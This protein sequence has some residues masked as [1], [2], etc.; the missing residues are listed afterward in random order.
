MLALVALLINLPPIQNYIIDKA[1]TYLTEG[2]GYKTEI[3]YARI[4]WFNSIALD[5][6]RIYDENGITMIG[7][8]ELALTFSLKD[9][10]GKKDISTKEA[11]IKGA[12]VNLRD[13]ST[14]GLNIDEWADRISTLFASEQNAPAEPAVFSIDQITLLDSKFSIS[15]SRKDSISEGFDYNHFQLLDLNADLLNLKTISDTFQIDVKKLST[16]D[17]ASGLTIDNLETF[18]R[19]SSKGLI[20]FD[21]DLLMGKTHIKDFVELSH[22]R[23][24]QMAYFVD[25]VD[26][27]ADF[28]HSIIHTDELSFFA[29]ELKQYNEFVDISGL[30]QG[31]VNRFYSDNFTIAF[32]NDSKFR[33]S[34]DIEGLPYIN[35]TIFSLNLRESTL[36]A[37][38]LREYIG[39][40]AFSI[41]NK[42]GLIKMSGNFDGLINNF[43]ADGIFDTRMGHLESN[44]KIEIED[45]ELPKYSGELY[46]KDF[47]LGRF[48]EVNNFQRID[49]D[50]SLTGEGF[51]F[52]TAN[53]QLDALIPKVG[54]NGYNYT[55]IETDGTFAESFFNGQIDVNDPML[56]LFA[57]GSVDLRDNKK[58]FKL[59][60]RLDSARF[61]QVNLTEQDMELSTNFNIDISGLKL[62][63]IQ[64]EIDLTNAYYR[65]ETQS[66]E[67][68][69]VFFVATR[70]ESGRKLTMES[71]L[72]FAD[73]SGDFEFSG[74]SNEL[75]NI[76]EQYRLQ[77]SSRA[78]EVEDFLRRNPRNRNNFSM[79]YQLQMYD[80]SPL[81]H[82]FDS[83]I[84]ISKNTTIDGRF[85]NQNSESLVLNT[86]VDTIQLGKI[87]FYDNEINI[88]ATDIRD[89]QKV[90]ALGY[91]SS[92]KQIYANSSET[93]KLVFEAVWDGTHMD[94]RQNLTQTS[95]GN[96]AEI[97]ADLNFYPD[98]TELRFG[99]S[100]ITI[101]DETW[102]ITDEN[103]IVFGNQKITV[104]N[105]SVFNTDQSISFNGEIA[106][107]QDS[108]QTLSASFQ[109]VQVSNINPLANEAYTGLVNGEIKAQNL[110]YNPVI[111]GDLDIREFRINDFLVGDLDGRISWND[112]GERFDIDFDVTRLGRNTISMAGAY[113]PS[114]GEDQLNIDLNLNEANINIAEPY[115]DDY[116]SELGGFINGKYRIS[117]NIDS[118]I[119][120][121][122]GAIQNGQ[123]KINYL[124]TKYQ[125]KG[126]VDFQNEYISLENLQF[127]DARN[128][129]ALFS[130]R[131]SHRGFTDFRLDLIG[132]LNQFQT[133]DTN[134]DNGDA[135]YGAAYA[136]GQ[137]TLTGEA[138]NLTISANVKTEAD[139]KIYIPITENTDNND[140]PEYITFVDRTLQDTTSN[141]ETTDL[142]EVNKIKIEGL[143]L[144]LDI[145]VTPDAYVEIIIDPKTGDII[146]GRGDGQLRLLVDTEGDFQM[147]GDLDITEG[148]YNFSLYNIITKEFNIEQPSTIT[149]YGD[150][151]AAIVDIKGSYKQNTSIAPLLEDAG[152]G[153]ALADG[154]SQATSR[155]VPTK[156]LLFLTGP[157]LSPEISFDIDFSE[158]NVNDY[159]VTTALNAFE[160]RIQSD[161][162]ELNRQVL[163]LIVLNHFQAQG[164][165]T[166]GGRSSTQNVSQLLSNQLSQLVAQLDENLEVNFDLADLDENSFNTFRLRLSYTFL[167]GRLRVT[168]EGGISNLVDINSIAGD[169]TAEYLLTQDGKYKVRVYSQ[170][171]YD[172]GQ[173][174]INQNATNQT[175]G[176]SIS[177][178]TSFNNLKEFFQGVNKKRQARQN[179]PS[180]DNP[181]GGAN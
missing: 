20:F 47:E 176:A 146:R 81:I 114:R 22:D 126:D 79:N 64:G 15:D 111:F 60:G 117:G 28:D 166:V 12:D 59:Q 121:G 151:Y 25:S 95:S 5:N 32:G 23:P 173:Q 65:Y 34:V 1:T 123:M 74:I 94:L 3:G 58:L 167:N 113:Y 108:A 17:S 68:D 48:T 134:Q 141:N 44:T 41:S 91:V 128:S 144:D 70:S 168:R 55:N 159:S 107:A 40:Q 180:T 155:R 104:E 93:D 169:W 46:L 11:W 137:V 43:V 26:V 18:F 10:I 88:N 100:N 129:E 124:N 73:F 90:L 97:G 149:W 109:N 160:T 118:P 101:L 45:G 33:G 158:A 103:V 38:D 8:D 76:N 21:L 92:E 37:T 83:T 145:E 120:R 110:Y 181:G 127:L 133:L 53:F 140:V 142:D 86:K 96:Y 122:Q 30:F 136:T 163:S 106:I 57:T 135:Y 172:L 174:A 147:T 102:Q 31:K 69:S 138:S 130:G 14:G 85:T 63:S 132:Q 98:R 39:K 71:D 178:T 87:N 16:R 67:L 162:Q 80:I 150:P 51:T 164:G 161:E 77:F 171:N 89:Q 152:F 54:I 27:R 2:T 72:L 56:K 116:F 4:K 112:F 105:L 7:I 156:V 119:M 35:Q 13:Y 170:S 6:T 84:Y 78:D 75:S 154:S 143:K 9:L 131:I 24:S 49:L 139:T 148:A 153:E 177:Q 165:L 52:E 66:I 82:I 179:P 36:K 175:R 125:F 61:Q 157:M 50:G 29:P 115:I 19:N 62:D 99:D 42:F